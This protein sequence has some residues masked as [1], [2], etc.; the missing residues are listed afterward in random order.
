M[1]MNLCMEPV[2]ELDS[3]KFVYDESVFESVF[4]SVINSVYE[5]GI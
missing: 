1:W 2:M 4:E 3:Y 5:S